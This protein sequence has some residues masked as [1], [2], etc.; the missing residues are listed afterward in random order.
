[1]KLAVITGASSGIGKELFHCLKSNHYVVGV[2]RKGP[3]IIADLTIGGDRDRLLSTLST[4]YQK[5]DI[6]VNNSGVLLLNESNLTECLSM[7]SINLVAVWDLT[8]R[9]YPYMADGGVIINIASVS[10]MRADPDTPLYGASKAGVISLT[11]SFAKKYANLDNRVR[12]NCI[13]PGFFDTN[14]CPDPVP[15]EL[16]NE[17]PFKRTANTKEI[18]PLFQ[19]ILNSEY[20][21]GVNI[22]IDGGLLL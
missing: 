22:P 8:N 11:K 17:I 21:T 18:L 2:G 9:I 7:L 14:L 15:Q 13:S 1:M 10:G 16:V 6:F 19:M 20:L 3:D 4:K 12:V 5:I